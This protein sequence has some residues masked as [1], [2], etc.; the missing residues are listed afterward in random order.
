M[1]TRHSHSIAEVNW[2][3]NHRP[4]SNWYESLWIFIR[5]RCEG[6][7][8]GSRSTEN[9]GLKAGSWQGVRHFEKMDT[10]SLLKPAQSINLSQFECAKEVRR[11]PINFISNSFFIENVSHRPE[12]RLVSRANDS[13]DGNGNHDPRNQQAELQTPSWHPSLTLLMTCAISPRSLLL[14]QSSPSR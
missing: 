5:I 14:I 1:L 13:R 2:I 9:D 3:P 11:E 12:K 6:W 7:K 4:V 8:R 10:D